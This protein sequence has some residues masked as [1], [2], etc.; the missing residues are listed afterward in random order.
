[1]EIQRYPVGLIQ[2]N[3]YVLHFPDNL[4]IMIDPGDEAEVV[5]QNLEHLDFILLTHAHWD[6]MLALCDV[7]AAFPQA[8]L[9]MHS[10]ALYS[11]AQ[12]LELMDQMNPYLRTQ[13]A[14][15]FDNLP[16]PDILLEDGS[17]IGPF[18]VLSTPGHTPGSV[19]YYDKNDGVLFSG[20]TLFENSYGRTDFIGGSEDDM[21]TSLVR[22]SREIP[23]STKLCPGHEGIST[24]GQAMRFIFGSR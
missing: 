2:T 1:M 12:Q 16:K 24:V 20:D 22:L 3:C 11:K 7:K 23:P 13:F 10:K 9:A 18:K 5:D 14:S 19:C 17:E 15:R 4:C 6:H 21:Y 8:K